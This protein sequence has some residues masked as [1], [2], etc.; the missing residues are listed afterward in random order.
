[1]GVTITANNSR[2]E[3]DIGYGVFS[4]F[5]INGQNKRR[6]EMFNYRGIEIDIEK[7]WMDDFSRWSDFDFTQD[8]A[9]EYVYNKYIWDKNKACDIPSV[10]STLP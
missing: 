10:I 4:S 5:R 9:D 6:S 3:F 8:I 1:M 7:K 2:H